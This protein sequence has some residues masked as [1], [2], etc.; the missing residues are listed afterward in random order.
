MQQLLKLKLRS[1]KQLTSLLGLVYLGALVVIYLLHIPIGLKI[2]LWLG[3]SGYV[4]YAITRFSL[5][6]A[7]LAIEYCYLDEKGNWHLQ[8]KNGQLYNGILCGDSLVTPYLTILSF[9][10][11]RHHWPLAITITPDA[12]DGEAF[13]QLRTYLRTVY[14]RTA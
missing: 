11:K 7:A 4:W 13:R 3:S 10:I 6:T 9:R 8:T 14:D 5:R 2:L 1:S 12:I